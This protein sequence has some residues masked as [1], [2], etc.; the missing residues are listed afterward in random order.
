[1]PPVLISA[2]LQRASS[3]DFLRAVRRLRHRDHLNDV[4]LRAADGEPL[5]AH[6]TM[7]H[8]CSSMLSTAMA[9]IAQEDTVILMPDFSR[10]SVAAMLQFVYTG[11]CN[12]TSHNMA[13]V[14][15]LL[16]IVIDR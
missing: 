9:D 14:H 7:L 15:Q 3:D 4:Q 13:E 2:H 10:E 1:M 12:V 11:E 6:R 8:M 16:S 5:R